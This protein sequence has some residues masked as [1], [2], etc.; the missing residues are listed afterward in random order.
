MNTQTSKSDHTPVHYRHTQ[1]G[2]VTVTALLAGMLITYSSFM[3]EEG[4]LG[5]YGIALTSGLGL[6]TVLFSSLITEV[7]DQEFRF[8]F[9]PGF[10]TRTFPLDTI[11]SVEVVRNPIWYGWGIRYTP[12]GWL[13]NVSGRS[14]VE[15]DLGT[16][17]VIRVGT[18]EP[19][20]LA[21]VLT[22]HVPTES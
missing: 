12:A 20:Q 16:E 8:Y 14:A 17:G 9:G 10:W 13:Y 1:P 7:T 4:Q 6:L 11:Q 19:E 22:R 21:Q 2:Y 15:I 3:S 5:M 18:D